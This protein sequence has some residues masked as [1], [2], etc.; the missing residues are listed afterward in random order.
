MARGGSET[1]GD[2]LYKIAQEIA[3]AKM[4]PDADHD[5]LS[6]LEQMV[7]QR[8]TSSVPTGTTQAGPQPEM[9]MG[10]TPGPEPA[11]AGMGV[12]RGPTP[13]PDMSGATAELERILAGS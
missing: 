1:F 7:I 13:S 2:S 4:A 3:R 9:A 5:F 6:E 12:S 8:Y 11:L 10:P